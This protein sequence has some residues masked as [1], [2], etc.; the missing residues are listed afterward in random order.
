MQAQSWASRASGAFLFVTAIA[1]AAIM[2]VSFGDVVMRTFARPITGAYEVTEMLVGFMVFA[3]L[4]LVTWR[5]EHIR[6]TFLGGLAMRRPWLRRLLATCQRAGLCLVFAYL[7][8][9][10]WRLGAQFSAVNARAIFAGLSLAP[11]AF[12]ASVMCGLSA[13]AAILAPA[14]RP[15]DAP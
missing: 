10:L 3:A 4:P 9:H 2:V 12:F 5:R 7:A 11:F 6:V 1:V 13:I 15:V 8:W 14:R